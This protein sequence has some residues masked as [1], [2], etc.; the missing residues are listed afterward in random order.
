MESQV[1]RVDFNFYDEF[2]MMVEPSYL[3]H[4]LA[5]DNTATKILP[6]VFM[7]EQKAYALYDKIF[8]EEPLNGIQLEVPQCLAKS[9]DCFQ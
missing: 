6:D 8:C 2:T 7:S 5:N 3:Q 9:A 1:E 4:Q